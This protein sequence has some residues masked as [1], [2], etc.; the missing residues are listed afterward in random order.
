[1]QHSVLGKGLSALIPDKVDF[2]NE[3]IKSENVTTI[4]TEMIRDHAMQPRANYDPEKLE[5]L[6]ASIKEKGI[7]QPILVRPV[8]GGYEVV[9]GERRL[10]AARALNLE[11]VPAVVR[12]VS[13]EEALILA[14][15]ENVQ[16]EDLNPI[17]AAQA[18]KRL[19]D[20]FHMSHE[21]IAQAVGKERSTITNI[22][23]L[24]NLPTDI[25]ESVAAAKISMGHARAL[26]AIED[27][28]SQ[29]KIFNRIVSKGMSV[30]EL[31][32]LINLQLEGIVRQKIL[33][34]RPRDHEMVLLEDELQRLLGTKVRI[35]AK[36]K[37]GK[38]V[39]EFYSLDDFDRILSLLKR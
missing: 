35:L 13:A 4:K 11:E 15:I 23:R 32:N 30:R 25:R 21:D 38:I 8:E 34:A 6:K 36:K 29:K 16:R 7:L 22:L 27:A 18:F 10:R 1:M 28:S 33:K 19:S 9:A 39:I 20:D 26:L 3:E 5:E 17:E 2:L 12:N 31:E 37:R 14:L 24:L